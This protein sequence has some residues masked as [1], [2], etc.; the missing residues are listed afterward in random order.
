M[1]NG[2]LRYR[3]NLHDFDCCKTCV[4]VSEF[5]KEINR[6]G[7]E[8]SSKPHPFVDYF[9]ESFP[10]YSNYELALPG[11]IYKVMFHVHALKKQPSTIVCSGVLSL[12]CMGDGK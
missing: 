9:L 6:G 11:D 12:K 3:C 8:F 2:I 7:I 4:E 10:G 1:S 5:F